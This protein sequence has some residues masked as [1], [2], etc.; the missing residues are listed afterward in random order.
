LASLGQ[1]AYTLGLVSLL[2]LVV[3]TWSFD[4]VYLRLITATMCTGQGTK[5]VLARSQ[6]RMT[7]ALYVQPE[8]RA[9][10]SG[11]GYSHER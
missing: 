5:S 9:F 7:G 10:L 6:L 11:G 8:A 2:D 1:R 4:L 3:L